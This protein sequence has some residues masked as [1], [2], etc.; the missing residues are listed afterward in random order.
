MSRFRSSGVYAT[1]LHTARLMV[2]GAETGFTFLCRLWKRTGR[3]AD[4]DAKQQVENW[5]S[6]DEMEGHL[7]DERTNATR[8]S[9]TTGL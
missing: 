4:K 9:D 5:L 7:Y 6:T 2:M 3:V 8:L 1:R